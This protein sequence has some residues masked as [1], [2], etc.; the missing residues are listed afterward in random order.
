MNVEAAH[1]N[2]TIWEARAKWDEY[3]RLPNR[4]EA[5]ETA[6]KAFR[7]MWQGHTVIDL[8]LAIPS[9]GLFDTGLPKF[10]IARAHWP[11]VH[12]WWSGGRVVFTRQARRDSYRGRRQQETHNPRVRMQ[13]P[14]RWPLPNGTRYLE[15]VHGR[16]QVP[17]IPP[18]LRPQGSLSAYHV[19]FE[20]KWERVP[21]VDPLL[22]SHLGGPFYVVRAQWALTPLEQ[23]LLRA[24]L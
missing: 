16:A 24:T 14:E 23:G 12:G 20:A 11:F 3:R 13:V 22:L 5:E 21:P 1:M 17:S 8:N 4:T 18:D 6:R 7:A 15:Q 10:A 19:L 2:T 9:A